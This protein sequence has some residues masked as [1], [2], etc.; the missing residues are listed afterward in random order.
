MNGISVAYGIDLPQTP[1]VAAGNG[2]G[3]PSQAAAGADFGFG[4]L[5]GPNRLQT[6]AFGAV[7]IVVAALYVNALYDA[8]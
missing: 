5:L 3:S 1:A 2:A 6:A 7:L 4:E 8:G